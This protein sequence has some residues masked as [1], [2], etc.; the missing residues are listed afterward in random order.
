VQFKELVVEFE[1]GHRGEEVCSG[2]PDTCGGDH[3]S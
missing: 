3:A 1:G 2:A